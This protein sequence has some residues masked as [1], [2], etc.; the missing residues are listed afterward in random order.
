MMAAA[1]LHIRVW[2][3]DAKNITGGIKM[4][5]SKLSK[6]LAVAA[7]AVA[8][9]IPTVSQA[10]EARP[11]VKLGFDFGGDNLAGATFTNGSSESIKANGLIYL[12]GGVSVINDDKDI[13]VEV[14]LAYKNDSI[15]ASNGSIDWTRYPLDMLVFYR[16]PKFRVGGGL[17]YHLHPKLSGSGLAS[18]VNGKFDDSLGYV[19]QADYL[20]TQKVSVGVRYTILDYKIGGTSIKSSGPG[21]TAGFR[22]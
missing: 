5:G 11:V 22:F 9:A 17:T 2:P 4:T 15:N 19:L 7:L 14:T 6:A 21:I 18:N 16:M 12:G 10:A 8:A 1:V 3:P 20:V 13:E